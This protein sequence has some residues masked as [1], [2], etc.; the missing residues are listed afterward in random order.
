MISNIEVKGVTLPCATHTNLRLSANWIFDANASDPNDTIRADRMEQDAPLTV[1]HA[2][3]THALPDSFAGTSS[4]YQL[5]KEY[6][7]T[8][9]RT[10]LDDI[11]SE[12]RHQ[13]NVDMDR[14][15]LLMSIQRQ[16]E[17][18]SVTI[19]HIRETQL[20]FV[21]R[22]KLNMGEL[23]EQMNRVRVEVSDMREYMQHVP[24]LVYDRG[25]V[26]HHKGWSRHH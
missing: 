5:R 24:H 26:R 14:D 15:V 20:D 21:E 8:S 12:L 2:Y 22:T 18:M 6:E 25:S 13:N 11:L 23:A 3:T 4:G 10:T 9:M 1:T 7:Y 19:N 16:H 17:E